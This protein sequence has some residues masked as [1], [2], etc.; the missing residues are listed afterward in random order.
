[1]CVC[2]LNPLD[3]ASVVSVCGGY[4]FF[5]LKLSQVLMSLAFSVGGMKI[6]F[7]RWPPL[8]IQ[9]SSSSIQTLQNEYLP[10][11]CALRRLS[12]RL[13]RDKMILPH[14][15][16]QQNKIPEREYGRYVSAC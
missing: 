7:S 14:H 16:V 4:R 6:K 10:I 1:M 11:S 2:T 9:N 3:Y 15:P 12:T 8:E 13:E 5:E